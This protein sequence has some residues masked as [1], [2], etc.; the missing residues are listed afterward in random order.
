[1]SEEDQKLS[2]KLIAKKAVFIEHE[3]APSKKSRK[4]IIQTIGSILGLVKD[5]TVDDISR[6]KEAAVQDLENKANLKYAEAEA[7]LAEAANLHAEAELK[8][9]Q[10][11]AVQLNTEADYA[12][13]MSEAIERVANAFKTLK[14]SGGSASVDTEQLLRIIT[15]HEFESLNEEE[16]DND[17]KNEIDG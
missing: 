5:Y 13:K 15:R 8:K 9:K 17:E 4:G 14:Q 11:Q 2:H 12:L 10:S 3:N 6:L 1:M 16:I 7:K